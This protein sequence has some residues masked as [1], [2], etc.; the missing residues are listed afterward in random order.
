MNKSI[1]ITL[2]SIASLLLL[3][4]AGLWYASSAIDPAKLV[5]LLATS[6]KSATGR[7]LKISGPVSLH[8]FPSITVS[9]EQVSLSNA[10]WATEPDILTLQRIE[11]DI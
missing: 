11:F 8:L 9:A 5:K 6:V 4:V 3:V 1:K 7:E 10:S 2:I